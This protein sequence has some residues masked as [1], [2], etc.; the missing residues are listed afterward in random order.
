MSANST[1]RDLRTDIAA[2]VLTVSMVGAALAL[3]FVVLDA[4]QG[5]WSAWKLGVLGLAALVLP[6]GGL[7][8][9]SG[10]DA[11]RAALNGLLIASIYLTVYF[12]DALLETPA[13]RHLPTVLWATGSGVT[14]L[15]GV[16]LQGRLPAAAAGDGPA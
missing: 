11:L 2:G 8:A 1:D 12:V 15:L 7:I 4:V 5:R 3:I 13:A 14:L 6:V 9:R 16:N 10:T